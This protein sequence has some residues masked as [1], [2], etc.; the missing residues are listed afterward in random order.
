[1]YTFKQ[2]KKL[3]ISAIIPL[4]LGLVSY[5]HAEPLTSEDYAKAKSLDGNN[6]RSLHPVTSRVIKVSKHRSNLMTHG[7]KWIN[8][9][10]YHYPTDTTE[11]LVYDVVNEK[12]IE[13]KQFK[14]IQFSAT[15]DEIAYA[16]HLL[17]H[18]PDFME[19]L[20]TEYYDRYHHPLPAQDPL[21]NLNIKAIVLTT[22]NT[23]SLPVYAETKN[24]G[25]HR[26][27]YFFLA[28]L[29]APYE[30]VTLET[31]AIV[32]LS[33]QTITPFSHNR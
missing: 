32:N 33:K 26:C 23:H 13:S 28:S 20:A 16:K 4:S 27:V 12:V 6:S 24:C 22:D 14:N 1:M 11:R 29:E 2:T 17:V 10:R 9:Y 21:S 18:D 19:Q 8:V 30:Y 3:F 31:K 5:V 25:L 15:R 7:S